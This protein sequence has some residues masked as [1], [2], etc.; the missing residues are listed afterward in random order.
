MAP[1]RKSDRKP[2]PRAERFGP[3][4]R[5][6][7]AGK[8]GVSELSDSLGFLLRLATG[9]ALA[10]L[11]QSLDAL[12]M[13]TTTYSVLLVIG[14]NPGLK[15]QEV[16]AALSIQPPNLVSLVNQ[17][18]EDGLVDRAVVPE[19]RRSYALSLTALGA[20]RLKQANEAHRAFERRLA[21]AIGA[22]KLP[23]VR[24][25]LLRVLDLA[26]ARGG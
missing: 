26:S 10:E 9:V 18:T 6:L 13:R 4:A 1:T 21:A 22:D 12:G 3:I 17:L 5:D 2:P 15:Q 23:A 11:A 25:G 14:E 19:D 20:A 7:R 8:L 16:G 24:E